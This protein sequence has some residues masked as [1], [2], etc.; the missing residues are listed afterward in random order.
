MLGDG[1]G[2]SSSLRCC[3]LAVNHGPRVGLQYFIVKLFRV[4]LFSGTVEDSRGDLLHFKRRGERSIWRERRGPLSM[5][6]LLEEG[7][8]RGCNYH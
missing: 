7:G 4:E 2:A 3:L 8:H 1:S 6:P 5:P